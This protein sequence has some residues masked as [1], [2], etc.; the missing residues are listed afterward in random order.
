VRVATYNIHDCIGRD[1]RFDPERIATV[2]A[3]FNADLIALQEVTLDPA[4]ELLG[5]FEQATGLIGIDGT[6][7]A[8]GVGRYGNLLLAREPIIKTRLHDLPC[9]GREP[10]GVIDSVVDTVDGLLRV[11]ATHL[12]LRNSERHAQVLRLLSLIDDDSSAVV[13]LI[14]MSGGVQR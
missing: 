1:G 6:L 4:G 2:L 8:R 7:F 5:R 14:S 3:E 13:L 10:R 9:A 12:G 11:F